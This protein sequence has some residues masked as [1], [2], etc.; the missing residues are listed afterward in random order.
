MLQTLN[1]LLFPTKHICLF[2]KRKME[3]LKDISVK[4]VM[5]TWKY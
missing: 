2:A 4:S 5:R 3:A 1:S